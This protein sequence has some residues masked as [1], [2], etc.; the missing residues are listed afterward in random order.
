[1]LQNFDNLSDVSETKTKL[2][3]LRKLLKLYKLDGVIIPK[4]DMHQDEFIEPCD[5]RLKWITG[6]TGSA[7]VLLLLQ[8]D[9][10]I[11]VDGRSFVKSCWKVVF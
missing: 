8:D 2:E 10:L 11:F 5:D 6:F 9:A 4:S 1:M 7:G 3:N